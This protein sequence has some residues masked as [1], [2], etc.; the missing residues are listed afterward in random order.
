M[1]SM[2]VIYKDIFQMTANCDLAIH[3]TLDQAVEFPMLET[4]GAPTRA[5]FSKPA[6]P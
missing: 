2:V 3:Q 5:K 6:T 1:N 4:S